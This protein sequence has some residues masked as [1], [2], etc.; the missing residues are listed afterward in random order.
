MAGGGGRALHKTI[1]APNEEHEAEYNGDILDIIFANPEICGLTFWQFTDSR[2]YHRGGAT[3]R[4][5]PFAMNLAG[6]YDGYRRPKAVVPVVKA[7]FARTAA[8]EGPAR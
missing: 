8:G 1:S 4:T 6:L 7:G 3:I 2:S 5:K